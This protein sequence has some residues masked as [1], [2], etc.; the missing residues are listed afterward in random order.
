MLKETVIAWAEIL[1][2]H[3]LQG[4]RKAT[5]SSVQPTSW[6]RFQ[7]GTSGIWWR[8]L[9]W[10]TEMF[11]PMAHLRIQYYHTTLQTLKNIFKFNTTTNEIVYK[12]QRNMERVK[13]YLT[14]IYSITLYPAE[15]NT[16]YSR[17]LL[18]SLSKDQ[19]IRDSL[20]G[21]TY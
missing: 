1:H 10:S 9:I 20:S 19:R 17:T 13:D 15:N 14:Q 8:S 21:K 16:Y 7:F 5:R 6:P 12:Q 3:L 4:L 11:V 18:R 2:W